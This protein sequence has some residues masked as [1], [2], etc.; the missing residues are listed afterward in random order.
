MTQERLEHNNAA[1]GTK[2]VEV[3]KTTSFIFL[4][5]SFSHTSS[6]M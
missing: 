3:A 6:I 4:L 5:R 2:N 1:Q